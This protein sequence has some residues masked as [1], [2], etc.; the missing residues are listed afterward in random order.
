M[1]FSTSVVELSSLRPS[2]CYLSQGGGHF[3]VDF[4]VYSVIIVSMKLLKEIVAQWGNVDAEQCQELACYF[5]DTPLIIKWGYLPREACPAS[6]V[7]HRIEAV[8]RLHGD[9]CREVFIQSA[10]F[11]KLKEVLGVK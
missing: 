6:R 7:A 4:G 2:S 8:E 10:S 11:Q 5:P 1:D 9:Y 3:F